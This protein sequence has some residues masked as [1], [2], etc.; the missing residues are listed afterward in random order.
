M[1]DGSSLLA[2]YRDNFCDCGNEKCKNALQKKFRELIKQ[3]LNMND[4]T[5]KDIINI[6]MGSPTSEKLVT[7]LTTL[8]NKLVIESFDNYKMMEILDLFVVIYLKCS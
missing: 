1:N 5:I 7:V 2:I 6:M 8:L 4:H 3:D